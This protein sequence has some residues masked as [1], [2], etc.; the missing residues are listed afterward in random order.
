MKHFTMEEQATVQGTKF[1][2][3][4]DLPMISQYPATPL[5]FV[6]P[7]VQHQLELMMAIRSFAEANDPADIVLPLVDRDSE[8]AVSLRAWKPLDHYH[9]RVRERLLPVLAGVGDILARSGIRVPVRSRNGDYL[10]LK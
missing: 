3:S 9:Q 8:M 10:T 7:R 4:D 2:V 5:E 6:N 1:I